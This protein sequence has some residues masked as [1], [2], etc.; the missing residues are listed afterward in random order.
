MFL[1]N[2][3]L[4]KPS[5]LILRKKGFIVKSIQEDFPGITDLDVMKIALM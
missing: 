5:T 2:E 4:P 3:K 1:A